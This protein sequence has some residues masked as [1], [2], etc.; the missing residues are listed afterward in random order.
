[1]TVLYVNGSYEEEETA[2]ISALDRGFLYGEGLFETLA[3]YGGNIF[4][5]ERHL[6]RLWESA[7]ALEI[8]LPFSEEECGAILEELL[9]KNGLSDAYIRLTVSRGTGEG[10]VREDA[11]EPT[12]IGVARPLKPYPDNLYRSGARVVTTSYHLGPLSRHK[13]LSFITNIRA[14]AEAR[15]RGAHEGILFDRRGDPAEC[16]ASNIFTVKD[17]K[18]ITPSLESGIL[19]GITRAEVIDICRVDGIPV[20]ERSL[21]LDETRSADEMFLTNTIMGVMGVAAVDDVT[22]PSER[23]MV[24]LISAKYFARLRA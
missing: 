16:S 20:E 11:G 24:D 9:S 21:L 6:S 12:V 3:A 17:G 14:R 2:A 4:R 10:M 22:L 13:T 8:L 18:V 5:P 15:K 19:P 23:P 7:Q 1:M